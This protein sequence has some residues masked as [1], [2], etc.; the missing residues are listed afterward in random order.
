M[1]NYKFAK[2]SSNQ[3]AHYWQF[4]VTV[5]VNIYWLDFFAKI[6]QLLYFKH[7]GKI[8]KFHQA[9]GIKNKFT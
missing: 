9:S 4:G 6:L 8:R 2:V 5:F 3:N 7:L 1:Q